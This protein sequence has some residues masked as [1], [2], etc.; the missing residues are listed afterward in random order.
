M[1]F[2]MSFTSGSPKKDSTSGSPTREERIVVVPNPTSADANDD[3]GFTTTISTFD[4]SKTY[5]PST[6]SDA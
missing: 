2:G 6:D 5:N 4:D 3:F 1:L